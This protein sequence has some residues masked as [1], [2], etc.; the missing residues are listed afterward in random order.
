MLISH[1]DNI[2]FVL[3]GDGENLDEIKNSV[4]PA[5]MDKII[6]LGRRSDVESI[7]NIFD[8]GILLTNTKVHGEGISNSIIEY[9]ALSKPVIATRGGGTNEVVM[10]NQNGYLIDMGNKNQLIEKIEYLMK[11]N[12]RLIELGNKGNQMVHEKFDLKIMTN[13]YIDIY[14]KLIREKAGL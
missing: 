7:I 9:M 11:N 1:H 8:I 10:D 6:F 2:R 5:A 14:K 13:N 3:V 12:D 4:S